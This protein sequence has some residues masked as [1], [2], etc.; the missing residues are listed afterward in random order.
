M[1]PYVLVLSLL[2]VA[3]GGS[4]GGSR[5]PTGVHISCADITNESA[6]ACSDQVASSFLSRLAGLVLPEA[7]AQQTRILDF[8]KL[9][10]EGPT[11]EESELAFI[12]AIVTNGTNGTYVGY[13]DVVLEVTLEEGQT[14]AQGFEKWIEKG[15]Y[16]EG[17][18]PIKIA[19]QVTVHPEQSVN[20]AGVGASC[21]G[22]AT[23]PG[24]I[25]F[26]LYNDLFCFEPDAD[27]DVICH[28]VNLRDQIVG[29]FEVIE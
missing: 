24:K 16:N 23:G 7:M 21:S 28:G 12:D 9:R 26:A 29:V 20:A 11:P 6:T 2:L 19:Q 1:K 22:A 17:A 10:F 3:C 5:T 4:S 13:V 18:W 27:G 15:I 14:C 8:G 25:T